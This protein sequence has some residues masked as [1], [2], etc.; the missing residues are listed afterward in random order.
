MHKLLRA[1]ILI[2]FG[3]LT[4]CI[5]GGCGDNDPPEEVTGPPQPEDD[6]GLPRATMVVVDPALGGDYIPTNTEFTLSFNRQV[7]AVTVNDTPAVGSGMVWKVWLPLWVGPGQ[8]LNVK[9]VNRDGS[10]D[11][12][13]VGPYWIADVHGEPPVITSGTVTDGET[14]VDPAQS[15]RVA[16]GLISMNVL[17]APLS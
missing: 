16:S 12:I 8:A 9:W 17:Q 10:T 1:G 5:I 14:D 11:T 7:V 6:V 3:M 2:T 15:M 4:I 13:K